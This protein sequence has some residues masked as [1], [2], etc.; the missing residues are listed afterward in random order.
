[1]ATNPTLFSPDEIQGA[2]PAPQQV[3]SGPSLFSPDE[4]ASVAGSGSGPQGANVQPITRSTNPKLAAAESAKDMPEYVGATGAA[5]AGTMG[6]AILEPAVSAAIAHLGG[7]TKIVQAAKA[8]G[9][10][11]FGL[12]EAHDLYKMASGSNSSK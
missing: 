5:A 10:T 4:I 2:T 12:K 3:P 9:W 1:M 6:A 8:L 11:T 7:L